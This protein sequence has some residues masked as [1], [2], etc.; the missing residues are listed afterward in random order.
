MRAHGL[1]GALDDDV[2][3]LHRVERGRQSSRHLEEGPGLALAALGLGEQPRVPNR[4]GGMIGEGLGKPDLLVGEYP[5]G[6]VA[7][8]EHAD[9]ALL[10]EQRQGHHRP[11]RRPLHA[12]PLFRRLRNSR[13]LEEVRGDDG[14]SLLG[15]HAGG[16][17]PDP[18]HDGLAPCLP[19]IALERSDTSSSVSGRASNR[20][21]FVT[22]MRLR[23]LSVIRSA[24]SVTSN[25]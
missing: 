14:L 22:P 2:E 7:Q 9:H 16:P 11:E 4:L 3:D 8:H 18:I 21:E 19:V 25:D 6:A 10:Q 12:R 23:T 24:T 13:I 1:H 20:A 17:E 15:G 5:P